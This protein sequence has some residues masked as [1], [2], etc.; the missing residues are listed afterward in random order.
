MTQSSFI[1]YLKKYFPGVVVSVVEKL[2]DTNRP[3]T[4]LHKQMLRPNFSVTGKWDSISAAYNRVAA[5]IVSMDSKLPLKNRDTISRANGDIP[6]MGMKLWLNETELTALDTLVALNSV[7]Q[8]DINRILAKL[9]ADTPRVIEGVYERNEAMFLQGLSTGVTLVDSDENVGTG[10]RLDY[11]YMDE[12]KFG[13]ATVWGATS[14]KPFDD[15]Q[16]VLDKAN[17]DGNAITRIM[18]SKTAMD[19]IL[20]TDQAKELYAFNLGFVGS[21][22]PA[23]DL[24]RMNQTTQARFGFVFQVVNRSIRYEKNG[25]RTTSKPWDEDNLIF[26]T[27]GGI[28]GELVYATLAEANRPVEG[29]Q[30]QTADNY[31]LVSKYRDNDP[32]SEYTSS[33]ARVCPV[34]GNVDQIYLMD[35]QEVQA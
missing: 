1:E 11:G 2:N 10:V 14:V 31:I 4:Y 33:Q 23:P 9:F 12:N 22:I 29:V 34:I 13:V 25:V 18:L 5:D 6:K 16:K 26:L 15:I 24:S 19:N 7:G 35:S 30:Y 20:K 28:V 27:D 17:I 8:A 21:N 3:L 32:L